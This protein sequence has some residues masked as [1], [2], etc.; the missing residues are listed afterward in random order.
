MISKKKEDE[1][2]MRKSLK[3]LGMYN[4]LVFYAVLAYNSSILSR[5]KEEWK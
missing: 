3:K 4:F 1:K 5:M 2:T